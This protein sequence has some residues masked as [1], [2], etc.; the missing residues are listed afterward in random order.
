MSVV[1]DL[2]GV[3]RVH[4]VGIGGAGMSAIARLLLASKP[5]NLQESGPFLPALPGGR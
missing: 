1:P 3:R 2:T 4:M 5:T